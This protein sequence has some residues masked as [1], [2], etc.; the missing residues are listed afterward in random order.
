MEE[1]VVVGLGWTRRIRRL[2]S[3]KINA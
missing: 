2:S 1:L 3:L